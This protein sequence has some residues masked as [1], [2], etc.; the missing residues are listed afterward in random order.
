MTKYI[1][2]PS[3]LDD[4]DAL[5]RSSCLASW[6]LRFRRSVSRCRTVS[7]GAQSS[8]ALDSGDG[9]TAGLASGWGGFGFEARVG[10]T[11][12]GHGVRTGAR[13]GAPEVAEV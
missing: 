2:R 4:F 1:M 3:R 7:S 6:A 8:L 13:R 9:L 11:E 5:N 12:V 10:L